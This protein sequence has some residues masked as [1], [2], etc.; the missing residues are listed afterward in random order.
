MYFENLYEEILIN[1]L[2][3]NDL[4]AALLERPAPRCIS[5]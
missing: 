5:P 3:Q 2:L 1:P 4:G